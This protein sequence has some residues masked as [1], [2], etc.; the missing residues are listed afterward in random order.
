MQKDLKVIS[1][2]KELSAV[3]FEI[4]ER[5][6]K[7]YRFTLV[8]RMQNISL[9]I[10][11]ELYEANDTYIDMKIISDMT[12]TID[13]V[14]NIKEFASEEERIHYQNKLFELKLTKAMKLEEKV[15]Q[16]LNHS[17]GALT[18]VK[19][20]DYLTVLSAQMQ[21]I[22]PKQQE[23]LAKLIYE[24]KALIGGFIKSDKQRYNY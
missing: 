3:I 10:I 8:S 5:S 1:K 15:T 24:L 16:R 4:T 12:K 11:A 23:R 14:K 21:C 17:Y 13:H 2:A 19:K 18:G 7:K 22:T 20:L 6:P 9:D